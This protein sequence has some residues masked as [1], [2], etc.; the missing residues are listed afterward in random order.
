MIMHQLPHLARERRL[1]D[2]TERTWRLGGAA[3]EAGLAVLCVIVTLI[4]LGRVTSAAAESNGL[5]LTPPMGWNDWDVDGCDVSAR[6]VERT[7]HAMVADGLKRLGYDYVNIDDCWMAASRN[8]AGDL[9]ADPG[10][11]PGGIKPVADYVHRLGLK[12]GIYEDAGITTCSDYPGSYGHE[13][14]DA[15]TFASW[16]VDYLKYDQ[17]NIPFADFPG[18]SEN[19]IDQ[20]LYTRMSDA[21]RATGRPIVFS[22]S[23]GG[24]PGVASWSWGP[25]VANLW[26][27]T[28]DKQDNFGSLLSNFQNNVG[29]YQYSGPGAWND[30][31]LLDIGNGGSTTLEY[32]TEFSLWA[33]MAAPLI[34]STNIASLSAPDLAIYKNRNVIAV[35]QDRLGRQARPVS[36]AG[37]LWVLSKPLYGGDRSVLLF[38]ATDTAATISTT[39]AAAGLPHAVAYRLV[40]LWADTRTETRGDISAFVPAH[41]VVMYRTSPLSSLRAARSLPPDTVLSLAATRPAVGYGASTIVRESITDDGVSPATR[42]VL[43]F[44]APRGWKV[45]PLSRPRAGRL[46]PGHTF[47]ARFRV[48]APAPGPPVTITQLVATASYTTIRDPR[49]AVRATLGELLLSP[50]GSPFGTA[51]T[52]GG[53]ATFGESR[54]AFAIKAAGTG[55]SPASDSYAAIYAPAGSWSTARVTVR[56]DHDSGSQGGSGLIQLGATDAPGGAPPAVALYVTPLRRIVVAWNVSGGPA[57]DRSFALPSAHARLPVTLRLVRAGTTYTGYYSTDG[58]STWALVDSVTVAAD[59]SGASQEVGMF[60]DSGFAGYTTEADFSHFSLM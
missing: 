26:R 4:F 58:G 41:G 42:I 59:A 23:D 25:P 7:A 49:Q 47:T 15:L 46:A 32:R 16:G 36:G 60:H 21:L 8:A 6:S 50:V 33:E 56:A 38:N 39:A 10:R 54:G 9:V 2:L 45:R 19:Q 18:W 55:I 30:P 27:T 57:L 5:A 14:Q 1:G 48:T 13:Q 20:T 3:R 35:D 17:C 40:D 11:F 28:G 44:H 31:D 37:G 52:T 12:L 53:L 22:M 29:L 43:S 34:A 51:N 24:Y